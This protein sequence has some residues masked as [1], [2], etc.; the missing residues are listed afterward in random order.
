MKAAHLESSG[1]VVFIS[2]TG[3]FAATINGA[4]DRT[5]KG[6][7]FAP[8]EKRGDSGVCIEHHGGCWQI[9]ASASIGDDC[10]YAFVD[11]GCALE[12]CTSRMWK[13]GGGKAFHDAPSVKLVTGAEA[14]R[15]V[16]SGCLRPA[17]PPP[18]S[19]C[20]CRCFV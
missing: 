18:P 2:A 17:I 14:M 19:L 7:K 1:D 8:Y 16:R 11:G 6:S 15:Q 3:P 13:V 9:K 4:Y 5:S 12:A 10:A 20:A